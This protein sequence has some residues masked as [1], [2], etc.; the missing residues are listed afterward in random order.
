MKTERFNQGLLD[1]YDR[2][3]RLKPSLL[4]ILPASI[5]IASLGAGFSAAEAILSGLAT[6][7]GF[8][9]VLA[10]FSRDYGKRREPYLFHSWGGKPTTAKLRHRDGSVNPHTLARYHEAA[11]R[12]TGKALPTT[13]E[14]AANPESADCIYEMVGDSLREKTRDAKKFP[15]LFKEL[16]SYG[17]RRNLFG[18]KSF[19]V[20]VAC[21][22]IAL[23]VAVAARAEVT[24]RALA[25]AP[26][27]MLL[28]NVVL[29]A[30]WLFI[31]SPAWVRVPADAYAER[32]LAALIVADSAQPS[33][34]SRKKKPTATAAHSGTGF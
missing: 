8:T 3:A 12:L 23:Q 15:L 14:E 2:N 10:Q 22:C 20:T 17:F 6:A 21:C 13:S 18:L 16:V 25:A 33:K 5:T 9:Y 29:L 31:V 19:G 1:E 24:H 7:A 4:C 11:A 34:A 26:L 27:L 28:A 30:G 32:L